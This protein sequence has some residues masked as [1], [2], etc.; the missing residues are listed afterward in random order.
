VSACLSENVVAELRA[1]TL[2]RDELAAAESHLDAC[3]SCREL[4]AHALRAT[5]PEP[6]PPTGAPYIGRYRVLREVGAGSMG[7]VYAAE[8]P[9]LDREVALKVLRVAEDDER[10]PRRARWH[11]EAR[12]MARLAHP[13]VITVHEIG[14]ADGK[15]FIAM[16]LVQGSTLGRWLRDAP[17]GWRAV[18]DVMCAAGRGLAAAHAAG[19]VHRDFKPDNVLV[20]DDGRVRVTDF[21]LAQ[22]AAAS[23]TPAAAASGIAPASA[24]ELALTG[25]TASGALVGTPAY[26]SPEQLRG[27]VADERSDLFS[28]CVTF[29]EALYG[30]RPFTG[31]DLGELRAA[32]VAG[33]VRPPPEGLGVP[34]RL[35]DA[36]RS[37]LHPAPADRP[38]ALSELLATIEAATAPEPPRAHA[39]RHRRAVLGE[40]S[41]TWTA[42]TVRLAA[43]GAASHGFSP[44]QL[45]ARFG[46]DPG[47]LADTNARV[48]AFE[49]SEL[50]AH[51]PR[52]VGDDHFGL[53]V[54]ELITARPL[55]FVGQLIAASPTLGQG[56]QRFLRFERIF[57]D[58]RSSELALD[59]DEAAFV[60]AVSPPRHF[61]EFLWAYFVLLARSMTGAVIVP[62]QLAFRHA[63]PPDLGE[64]LRVF[65]MRP[66][67]DA[68]VQ[69]L[70]LARDDFER[71][72]I[73]ADS[74]LIE[75]LES[76][77]RE[78]LARLPTAPK[79][80]AQ[81]RS[82]VQQAL[83]RGELSAKEV[84]R[85]LGIAPRT[86]QR[87]LAD[88]HGTT[89]RAVIGDLRIRLARQ[90]LD[91]DT[92]AIAEIAAS[93]G[94]A[95]ERAFHRAFVRRAGMTPEQFRRRPRS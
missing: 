5:A 23:A 36:I 28:F 29:W 38:T 41:L 71:A 73:E 51:V 21:G 85:Q 26:M 87:R 27:E 62:R 69:Q 8:D 67:F 91:D 46:L 79:L 16:E 86:L 48:P 72:S 24:L 70:V 94:F 15:P 18:V 50:W 68:D 32:V 47:L 75:V 80:I 82:V 89:F 40:T 61:A 64:H 59:G 13:N 3:A 43:V 44:E 65:G 6:P 66:S 4:V 57:H 7:R 55:G 19:I 2:Q 60:L 93:L 95:S 54:A 31:R 10:D 76:H 52:L 92:R 39:P 11:R 9:D 25:L 74:A 45:C 78:Q 56:L 33:A 17:R 42:L 49:A 58:V 81:V 77:A 90:W 37:G 34:A 22:L 35:H 30:E 1:G 14:V 63:A 83:A 88:E 20:G 84:A 12:A 53:H